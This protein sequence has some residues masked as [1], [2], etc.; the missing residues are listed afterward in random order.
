MDSIKKD[1]IEHNNANNPDDEE[2][3]PASIPR[4]PYGLFFDFSFNDPKDSG[5]TIENEGL[6][7]KNHGIGW[8]TLLGNSSINFDN[9][10]K[11]FFEI[12]INDISPAWGNS[13]G[14]ADI[15]YDNSGT[16]ILGYKDY[17]KAKSW[18]WFT[19]DSCL[20]GFLHD[21]TNVGEKPEIFTTGDVVRIVIEAADKSIS[22][23]KNDIFI[24]KPFVD[25]DSN[26]VIPAF[27][28]CGEND[29]IT[30]LK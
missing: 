5:I 18:A 8:R 16:T 28:L 21:G 30:I 10:G 24:G 29:S 2:V 3:S 22:F 23:Y 14:V 12:K 7:G 4:S 15:K 9:P 13:I 19:Y 27:T 25:I 26:E 6:T 11:Y 20:N 17:G 1:N